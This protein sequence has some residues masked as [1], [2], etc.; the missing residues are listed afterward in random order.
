MFYHNDCIDPCRGFLLH[1][2]VEGEK[3][4]GMLSM[5][6]WFRRPRHGLWRLSTSLT[7]LVGENVR[8]NGIFQSDS[9]RR[10]DLPAVFMLDSKRRWVDIQRQSHV[11]ELALH[12]IQPLVFARLRS[13]LLA[14]FPYAMVTIPLAYFSVLDKSHLLA[15]PSDYHVLQQCGRLQESRPILRICPRFPRRL[16]HTRVLASCA[17]IECIAAE[18]T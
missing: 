5:H 9:F 3:G 2:D 16:A 13:H 18:V 7:I 6:P 12:D 4:N 8:H 14:C 17:A 10:H 1:I 15:L 11:H